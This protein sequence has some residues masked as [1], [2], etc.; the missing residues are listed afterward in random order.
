MITGVLWERILLWKAFLKAVGQFCPRPPELLTM[1]Q[2]YSVAFANDHSPQNMRYSNMSKSSIW[3]TRISGTKSQV[4]GLS[5]ISKKILVPAGYYLEI[6]EK[7]CIIKRGVRSLS[8]GG[9]EKIKEQHVPG[10]G[11]FLARGACEIISR[12]KRA[13]NFSPPSRVFRP[14]LGPKCS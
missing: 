12:A 7:S 14:P 4:W 6:P 10:R 9:G 1:G 8:L 2:N 3:C 13:K 5:G 11:T